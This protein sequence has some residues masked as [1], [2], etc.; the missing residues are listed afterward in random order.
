MSKLAKW[1]VQTQAN[2]GKFA[3]HKQI[4]PNGKIS[5]F[6]SGYYPGEAILALL[7]LYN[8]DSNP[9]WLNTADKAAQYLILKRDK[10][11]Q[12]SKL[13]HDHWFLYALNELYRLRSRKIFLKHAA[14]IATA[15]IQKQNRNP[16]YPDWMGSYYRPPRSASTAARSEGLTATYKLMRD[17]GY[18]ALANEILKTVMLG[19]KFQF[20]LQFRPENALYLRN[21]Q[22]VIGGFM[23][24]MDNYSIRIDYVQHNISSFL[25]L[26]HLLRDTPQV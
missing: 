24:S 18:P 4:Y 13:P 9:Q 10:G 6:I 25:L 16:E 5:E 7:R 23:R 20:Q 15:I 17:Y 3:I 19:V 26:Y 11:L 1:I 22:T 8:I 21:P 12:I 2:D 14:K